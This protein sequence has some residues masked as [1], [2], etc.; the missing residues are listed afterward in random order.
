MLGVPV[1]MPRVGQDQPFM[2]DCSL[3][4]RP[5]AE[6]QARRRARSNTVV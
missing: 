3:A 1:G 5:N 4:S 2:A 6:A